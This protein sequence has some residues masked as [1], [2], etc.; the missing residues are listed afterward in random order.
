MFCRNKQVFG[1]RVHGSLY[2]QVLSQA[3]V[4]YTGQRL[5][6]ASLFSTPS[7]L[8]VTPLNKPQ[9]NKLI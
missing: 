3:T 4:A 9:K 7:K 1:S 8:L 2:L 5:E 6:R